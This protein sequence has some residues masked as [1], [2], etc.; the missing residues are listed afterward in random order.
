MPNTA[1]PRQSV[2]PTNRIFNAAS[3]HFLQQSAERLAHAWH[4]RRASGPPSP[5]G[6]FPARRKIAPNRPEKSTKKFFRLYIFQRVRT[7]AGIAARGSEFGAGQDFRKNRD[8]GRFPRAPWNSCRASFDEAGTR[9]GRGFRQ[10]QALGHSFAC[11]LPAR[12]RLQT[13][14]P[15]AKMRT[16][17]ARKADFLRSE[18]P[19]QHLL[20]FR[21]EIFQAFRRRRFWRIVNLLRVLESVSNVLKARCRFWF[22]YSRTESLAIA[23]EQR[24]EL[25]HRHIKRERSKPAPIRPAIS[26]QSASSTAAAFS[27]TLLAPAHPRPGQ[28]PGPPPGSP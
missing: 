13:Y 22:S 21:H 2:Q 6:T 26:R 16:V 7:L 4:S 9:R 5:G 18:C 3:S 14:Q 25:V 23:E 15:V 10:R 27:V 11:P 24:F 12:V 28:A 17:L 8:A 20:V 1:K 19:E